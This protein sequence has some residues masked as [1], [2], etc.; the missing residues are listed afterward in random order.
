M[1]FALVRPR[2]P[3]AFFLFPASCFLLPASVQ[4][5]G[6]EQMLTRVTALIIFPQNNTGRADNGTTT[7]DDEYTLIVSDWYV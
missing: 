5:L 1:D 3:L 2:L 6:P 7:W 4:A